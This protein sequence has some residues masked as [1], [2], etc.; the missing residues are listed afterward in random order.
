MTS[1]Q[2]GGLPSRVVS[3]SASRKFR[4]GLI[5]LRW[6]WTRGWGWRRRRRFP[7]GLRESPAGEAPADVLFV[8]RMDVLQ[9][10]DVVDDDHAGVRGSP[11]RRP[12]LPRTRRWSRDCR[13]SCRARSGRSSRPASR[14]PRPC[15][16]R[17]RAPSVLGVERAL[18][19][20]GLALVPDRPAQTRTDA[21]GC[22]MPLYSAVACW[23]SRGGSSSS[24]NTGIGG[25]D[26]ARC[27][28]LR[29]NRAASWSVGARSSSGALPVRGGRG[30]PH[31]TAAIRFGERRHARRSPP[32]A[33]RARCAFRP[34]WRRST[35]TGTPRRWWSSRP[36]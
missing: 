4:R 12:G 6:P 35:P 25:Q 29:L 11:G 3:P 33:S 32:G 1:N 15:A 31:W 34:R 7:V 23:T 16:S 28:G 21:R 14:P 18:A 19:A 2:D 8:D 30:S 17:R 20:V 36:K 5:R 9:V 10:A 24:G 22:S 27:Q 13:R 26:F